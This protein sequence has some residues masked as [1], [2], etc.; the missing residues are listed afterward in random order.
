MGPLRS[1]SLHNILGPRANFLCLLYGGPF[2]SVFFSYTTWG[3]FS[4]QFLC[5][6]YVPPPLRSVSLHAIGGPLQI[7]FFT[8]DLFVQRYGA[9]SNQFLRLL[10]GAPSDQFLCLIFGAPLISVFFLTIWGPLQIFCL[11]TIWS[12]LRSFTSF[13]LCGALRSVFSLTIWGAPQISFSAYYIWAPPPH[14]DISVFSYY[15]LPYRYVLLRAII[16]PNHC[17]DC[18][19]S[20]SGEYYAYAI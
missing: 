11:H 4:D 2:R 3:L 6:L 19:S 16:M 8:K 12:P 13:T 14:P 17:Q 10:Y 1:V 9:P 20:K 7:S 5:L 15:M 18:N